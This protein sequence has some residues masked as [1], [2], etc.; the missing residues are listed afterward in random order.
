MPKT[1][2]KICKFPPCTAEFVVSKAHGQRKYCPAHQTAKQR[3]EARQAYVMTQYKTAHAAHVPAGLRSCGREGC[4]VVFLVT[5]QHKTY[6][7]DE[8]RVQDRARYMQERYRRLHPPAEIHE[9]I[10]CHARWIPERNR[11]GTQ[12][13]SK[14]CYNKAYRA[15]LVGGLV[16]VL[17]T[18]A[19]RQPSQ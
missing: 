11:E 18:S 4:N 12:V 8:C 1:R 16:P 19:S 5:R 10:I 2:T 3:K 17:S 9:C 7:S 13:C 6:C 14:D 15:G